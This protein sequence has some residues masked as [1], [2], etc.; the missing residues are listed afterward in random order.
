M[1][2]FASKTGRYIFALSIYLQ[3]Y[4]F[5]VFVV[6]SVSFDIPKLQYQTVH[7]NSSVLSD[8]ISVA[9]LLYTTA[10]PF[11]LYYSL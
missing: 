3:I 1:K 5:K 4:L 10:F 11:L 7:N 2:P 6:Y 9:V 8:K